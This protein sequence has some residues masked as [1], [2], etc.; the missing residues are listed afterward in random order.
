M[1]NRNFIKNILLAN[2]NRLIATYLLFS[3][4]MAGALLKPFFLGEAVNDLLKGSYKML[5]IFLLLHLTWTIVG[6][7]RMRL[8]TRTYTT[9]YNAIITQFLVRNKEEKNVS[10]LSALSTLSREYTDFLEFDLIF[11]LEAIYNITG[12]LLIIYFYDKKVIFVCICILI[13]IIFISKWYGKKMG[14]LTKEKNNELEKQID[15]IASF[16]ESKIKKHYQLLQK[17]QVK[18]SDKQAFNFGIMEIFVL[19]LLGI[20]LILSTQYSNQHLNAGQI[21]SFYFYII[22]FTAGLDTLPY[23]TEKYASLKDITKRVNEQSF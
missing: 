2:R 1:T 8:D 7:C 16:D 9:I 21:I 18:L 22:K 5:I 4:E 10:K 19:L 20:S 14:I 17:W 23:L 13:P 3:L 15:I 6:M 12:S 11:M